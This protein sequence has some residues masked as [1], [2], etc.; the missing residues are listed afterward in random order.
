[1]TPGEVSEWLKEIVLKTIKSARASWVRIPLSPPNRFMKDI[2]LTVSINRPVRV[3]FGYAINPENTPNWVDGIIKEE[4]NETPTKLG[5]IYK[6]QSQDGSWREFEITEF[7]PGVMFTMTEKNS[8]IHVRYTFQ[9]LND[10]QCELG[11]YVWVDSG[12]LKAPFTKD[13]VRNIIQKLKDV[14]EQTETT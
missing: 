9:P 4:T 7:K 10:K 14:I 8:N 12:G 2:T 6:N 1:M 11:Y 5:T 3:S 13:N